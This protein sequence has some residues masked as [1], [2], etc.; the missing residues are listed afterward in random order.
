VRK[1][2]IT[3]FIILLVVIAA[4]VGV[5]YYYNQV[6]NYVIT[7]NAQIQG[8]LVPITPNAVGRLMTW[9]GQVGTTVSA[10]QVIG[11]D[12]VSGPTG[13]I[14]SPISGTVVQSNA[15]QG[16][17]VAP[18]Q[19]L[20]TVV[21]MNKL[22]VIANIDETDINHVKVGQ[23]VDVIVDAFSGTLTGTVN[24]IGMATQSTFSLLPSSNTTGN[25]T[26]QTQRIPVKI[27]LQDYSNNLIPGL[28][29][30]VRIHR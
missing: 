14:T 23:T 29:A 21:D 30:S 7:D 26:K 12:D 16:E 22:Y 28:N 4:I 2:I 24:Q 10:N 20:A 15:I 8:D 6:T 17:I 1:I 11:T 18:G 3:N 9:N 19:Q 27:T 5:G 25:Y 13:N